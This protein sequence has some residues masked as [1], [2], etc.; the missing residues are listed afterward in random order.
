MGLVY[1]YY[2]ISVT[3]T[4]LACGEDLILRICTDLRCSGI[5]PTRLKSISLQV[6]AS[7]MVQ[8][9]AQHSTLIVIQWLIHGG[10]R[11]LNAL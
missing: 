6:H 9:T 11:S 5:M 4:L 8:N 7:F 3:I 10:C 2:K 1:Y